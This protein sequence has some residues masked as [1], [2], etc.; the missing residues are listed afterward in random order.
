[1]LLKFLHDGKSA[2]DQTTNSNVK[3]VSHLSESE[4]FFK[5][6]PIKGFFSCFARGVPNERGT[7][8]WSAKHGCCL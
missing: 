7:F 1:M 3:S 5:L 4:E 8:A 6:R 2:K